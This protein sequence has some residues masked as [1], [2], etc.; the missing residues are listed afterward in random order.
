MVTSKFIRSSFPLGN[1]MV[2][3]FGRFNSLISTRDKYR[4]K[5]N[6]QQYFSTPGNMKTNIK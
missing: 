3:V 2:Q 5:K 6:N 4:I 1:E